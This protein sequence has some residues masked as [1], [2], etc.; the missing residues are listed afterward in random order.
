MIE[1]TTVI[2]TEIPVQEAAFVQTTAVNVRAESNANST[3]LTTLAQN[4]E[5]T[6]IGFNADE[7]WSQVELDNG[8]IGWIASNLLDDTPVPVA[9][10]VNNNGGNNNPPPNGNG[11]NGG[12]GNGNGN[13]NGGRGGRGGNGGGGN[14]G[15]GS[16]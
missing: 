14:G 8:T 1:A 13:G 10:P 4:A 2:P 6:I 3:I 9:A 15:G 16:N 11:G 7:S 5:V 12:R